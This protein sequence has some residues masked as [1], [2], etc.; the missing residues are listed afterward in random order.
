MQSENNKGFF[1]CVTK[2]TLLAVIISLAGVLIFA[3]VIKFFSLNSTA[4]KTVNQ[5][6]KVLAVFLGCMIS[7]D[8]RGGLVKGVFTG[9]LSAVVIHL[10]FALFIGNVTFDIAFIVD[11]IFTALVGGLSGVISVNLKK[12]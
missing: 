10:I 7:F 6:I 1:S 4:I 2:G 12:Q 9:I 11:I 5:F 8:G 3:F